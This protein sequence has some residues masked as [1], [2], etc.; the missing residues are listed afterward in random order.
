MTT[1]K[2]VRRHRMLPR[3]CIDYACCAQRSDQ[4]KHAASECCLSSRLPSSRA[5]FFVLSWRIR[6][7]F[8]CPLGRLSSRPDMRFAFAAPSRRPT[9]NRNERRSD[10][11]RRSMCAFRA[12]R[13]LAFFPPSRSRHRFVDRPRAPE[14]NLKSRLA[15]PFSSRQPRF[16][17]S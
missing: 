3:G 2:G 13:F 10:K 12:V 14:P 17:V 8:R 5:S 9:D 16:V 15:V 1:R 11:R 4:C 6:H 7:T